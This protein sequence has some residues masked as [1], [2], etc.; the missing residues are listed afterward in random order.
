MK[1]KTEMASL[2]DEAIK[3]SLYSR[4]APTTVPTN[5]FRRWL[6]CLQSIFACF[7]VFLGTR[8]AHRIRLG[9]QSESKIIHQQS[10]EDNFAFYYSLRFADR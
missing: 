5:P 6:A 1:C 3:F 4:S 10:T 8:E 2:K 9:E 7:Y